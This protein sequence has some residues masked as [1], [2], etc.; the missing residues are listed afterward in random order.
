MA[1][2]S[3]DSTV[4]PRGGC[5]SAGG[6]VVGALFFGI[7]LATGTVALVLLSRQVLIEVAPW[8]W[9]ETPCTI[10]SSTVED[11]G[12]T[13]APYLA[14]IR[15]AYPGP[16][17][18]LQSDR[19]HIA[20][21]TSSSWGNLKK[22]VD[23][24]PPGTE[25]TCRVD[26]D[27]PTQAVL[28]ASFPG[29]VLFL[30]IPL[31]FMA[32]GAGG[33]WF[34]LRRSK[35]THEG[36]APISGS[37]RG[38]RL[39]RWIPLAFGGIFVVVG[40]GLF[41]GLGVIPVARMIDAASWPETECTIVSSEV[42]SH[43]SDDGTT[44]S[45]D[46][47][48]SYR[49]AGRDWR[50][51]RYDFSSGSSSGYEGKRKVVDRYPPGSTATCYVDPDDPS[52]AVLDR[53]FH[54]AYLIGLFGLLFMAP[55]L[56]VMVWG[57]R[58]K[59]TG[60]PISGDTIQRTLR[61]SQASADS[62]TASRVA[63]RLGVPSADDLTNPE[64]PKDLEPAI[65]PGLKAV[66]LGCAALFWNGIVSI[67]VWQAVVAYRSGSSDWGLNLFLIPFVLVGLGL[68]VGCIYSALATANPRPSLRV[69][70]GSPR[71]GDSLHIEWRMDGRAQ[72]LRRLEIVL[73]GQEVATYRRGT[74]TSTDRE[75]FARLLVVASELGP[76]FARGAR[77][78]RI[79]A[80][81]MHSFDAPSNK[82]VWAL[83]VSGDVPHWPDVTTD[84]PLHIRPLDPEQM[85]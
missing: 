2:N 41:I 72:R 62:E 22:L 58:W 29:S 52:S 23:R 15:F 70:P 5:A 49:T 56:A 27:D 28:E 45:I 21:V 43:Q 54:A 37:A 44:Y 46:I 69:T 32:V 63:A 68:V 80:D 47:L 19:L 30:A 53:S 14:H 59:S 81:T 26:P 65:G 3:L 50:S 10:V 82:I 34:T 83:K 51:N 6:R 12:D 7:F 48:Y 11:T 71:L 24:F 8:T 67:F 33:V 38:A 4:A 17:G 20:P 85:R 77:D 75:D 39:S 16:E 74:T 57:S 36:E 60:R 84:F 76:E 64:A 13:D 79:P 40:G 78:L 9:R 55:G 73:V 61:R 1:A 25:T 35:K 31:V 42:E 66:G 18:Q